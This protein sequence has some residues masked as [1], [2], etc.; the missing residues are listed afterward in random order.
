MYYTADQAVAV[1]FNQAVRD[2]FTRTVAVDL[3]LRHVPIDHREF[4]E[5]MAS[6]RA[7]WFEGDSVQ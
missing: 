2:A 3:Q 4:T 7:L 5:F 1:P 6:M